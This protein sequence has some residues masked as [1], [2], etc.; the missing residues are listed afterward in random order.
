MIGNEDSYPV[1]HL[2]TLLI[3][4]FT[5]RGAI[6]FVAHIRISSVSPLAVSKLYSRYVDV[7]FAMGLSHLSRIQRLQLHRLYLELLLCSIG[8][9]VCL[10][11]SACHCHEGSV[12]WFEARFC[13]TSGCVLFA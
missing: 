1:N 7:W 3:V 8:F 4:S 9:L 13:D 5:V 2:F 6:Y 10:C 11:V 12:V